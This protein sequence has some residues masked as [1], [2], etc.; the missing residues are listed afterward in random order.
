LSGICSY[1][2]EITREV[3]DDLE[4]SKYQLAEYRLS[5]YGRSR[6]EWSKLAAWVVDNRLASK[7]VRR[8]GER[9]RLAG[10]YGGVTL[11]A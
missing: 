4:A 3:F 6:S 8:G 11:V 5:I 1:L 7:Q 10:G 9:Q 2:A